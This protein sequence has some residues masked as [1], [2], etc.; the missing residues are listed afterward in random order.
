[1]KQPCALNASPVETIFENGHL[2][3]RIYADIGFDA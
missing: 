1:M 3:G 2:I